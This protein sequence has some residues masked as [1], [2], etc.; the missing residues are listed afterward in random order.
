MTAPGR[1]A[2]PGGTARAAQLNDTDRGSYRM[3][4]PRQKRAGLNDRYVQAMRIAEDQLRREGVAE[5]N[6][7]AAAAIMVGN[8]SAESELVPQ[9]VHDQGTGYGL[10]G[11][12]NERRT[13]MLAWLRAN[14]YARDSLVGQTRYMVIEAHRRGGRAWSSVRA[15]TE[16]N[17]SNNGLVFEHFFEG[18]A[19]D[20]NRNAQIREAYRAHRDNVAHRADGGPL[21]SGQ[22]AIVGE[23][24]P[25][26]FI[27]NAAGTV[28]PKA[29]VSFA[30]KH[31]RDEWQAAATIPAVMRQALRGIGEWLAAGLVKQYG[32]NA[33]GLSGNATLAGPGRASIPQS[34]AGHL[35]PIQAD[36]IANHMRMITQLTTGVSPSHHYTYH[37]TKSDVQVAQVNINTSAANA[38]GIASTIRPALERK[39]TGFR[40]NYSLV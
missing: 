8:A 20:N 21:A 16:A 29:P 39:L 28:V 32:P 19:R 5:A 7:H 40:A 3:P 38:E 34:M 26:L 9:T 4:N 6:I 30:G 1:G 15:A 27:P 2:T 35:P 11:A 25:E 12:R 13:A 23:R 18:P 36:F 31:F 33:R 22:A 24:G 17:I 10:Y 14:G 37:N